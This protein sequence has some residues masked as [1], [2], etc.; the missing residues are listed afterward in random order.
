MEPLISERE[1]IRKIF[2]RVFKYSP[3][4]KDTESIDIDI[5]MGKR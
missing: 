3:D 1:I 2:D 4:Y 5:M